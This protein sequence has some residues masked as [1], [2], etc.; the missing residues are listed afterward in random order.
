MLIWLGGIPGT[1]KSTVVKELIMMQPHI[2][3][4]KVSDQMLS[5]AGMSSPQELASLTASQRQELS[6]LAH[7][8]LLEI[9]SCDP[10][11]I[12]IEDGHFTVFKSNE[13][14]YQLVLPCDKETASQTAG[15]LLLEAPSS[16]VFARLSVDTPRR[17]E[18]LARFGIQLGKTEAEAYHKIE[19]HQLFERAAASFL[20]REMEASLHILHNDGSV[21]NC[22]WE[23]I[24]S[25]GIETDYSLKERLRS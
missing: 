10:N 8:K 5:L 18:R 11:T 7:R 22:A 17:E 12:R 2:E 15:L 4:V 9:D 16:E 20:S 24:R 13:K 3:L 1:G 19:Q 25:L 6:L 23:I 21:T 14:G